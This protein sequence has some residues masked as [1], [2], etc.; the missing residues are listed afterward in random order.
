MR[1]RSFAA[2]LT[3]ALAG[4]PLT[5]SPCWAC[6]CVGY[7]DGREERRAHVKNADV[8]FT[9]IVRNVRGGDPQDNNYYLHVRFRVRKVY[10]GKAQKRTTVH[11]AEQGSACGYT[12]FKEGRRYTVFARKEDRGLVTDICSGTKRGRINHKRYGLPRGRPPE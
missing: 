5:A 8:I 6:S 10:K 1:V 7:E 9:G 4:I 2:A 3:L 12:S 11:T